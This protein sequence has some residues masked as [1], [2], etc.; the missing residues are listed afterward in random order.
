MRCDIPSCDLRG[1]KD[2]NEVGKEYLDDTL[3]AVE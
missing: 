1:M 2:G 3:S